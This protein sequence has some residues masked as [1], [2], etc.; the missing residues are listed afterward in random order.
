M[1]P[2]PPDHALPDNSLGDGVYY[3]NHDYAGLLR[4]LAIICIDSLVLVTIYLVGGTLI[5]TFGILNPLQLLVSFWILAWGY[6][7]VMKSTIRTPGYWVTR[8]RVVTLRGQRPS[9]SR[10]TFR[11]LLC[12]LSPFTPVID[13]LWTSV[14][15]QSQTLRDRFAGTCVVR[16]RAVPMGTGDVRVSY[17]HALSYNLTYAAVR[18]PR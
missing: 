9:V 2:S 11:L 13:L 1:Q 10:M 12:L 17:Y 14:D 4:R 7:T 8:C 5:L 15:E 6:L 16:S 18:V 3:A